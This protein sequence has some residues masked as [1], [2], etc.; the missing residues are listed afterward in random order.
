MRRELAIALRARVTWI[1]AA[2][3]ALLTGHGF[4]LALDVYS[5]ASRSALGHALMLRELD[6][7]AGIVRPTMGGVELAVALFVPVV[8]ARTLAVEKER[9]TFGALA[10]ARGCTSAVLSRKLAAAYAAALLVLLSPVALFG[11]F[12]AMGGHLD[13]FE[14][15]IALT[16]HA[17]HAILVATVAVAAAAW[18]RTVAQATTAAIVVSASSWAVDAGEGF[19]ALAW[20]S[21]LEAAS[22]RQRLAPFGHGIVSLGAIAWFFATASIAA[23]LA[24]LGARLDL[25]PRSRAAGAAGLGVL[26]LL[27]VVATSGLAHAYDW[28]ETRRAS[29]PPAAVR[30]LRALSEPIAIEV[31]MDRD[32]SR[33]RQVERDVLSKLRLARPDVRIRSPLDGLEAAFAP[34][35]DEQYGRIVIRVGGHER[36]TRST[37][38]REIVT[39]V[40]DA[41]G[42]ALPDWSQPAYPGHPLVV[43]GARRSMLAGAAYALIPGAVLALGLVVTRRRRRR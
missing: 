40:F 23:A 5:A 36:E 41:A 30:E 2:L 11:L 42:R 8:A 13:V 12:V 7:L 24:F 18:T 3:A 43:E 15:L 34:V 31:W 17:L 21:P 16:G 1:A 35:H 14:V 29:L 37:S 28:S 20:L 26:F 39:L 4:V 27:S 22:I 10:L 33:R 32:D 38:R 9:G 19:A 6:P 25:R